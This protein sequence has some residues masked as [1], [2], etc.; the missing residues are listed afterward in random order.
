MSHEPLRHEPLSIK[1]RFVSILGLDNVQ[2]GSGTQD[3]QC[4]T[5]ERK[6][7]AWIW[8]SFFASSK[9][10]PDH[11]RFVLRTTIAF[12][13]CIQLMRPKWQCLYKLRWK[14]CPGGLMDL[15]GSSFWRRPPRLRSW[16][17]ACKTL[18]PSEATWRRK[19][20]QSSEQHISLKATSKFNV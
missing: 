20:R 19:I 11:F 17:I 13:I 5:R 6:T 4:A 10:T 16:D 14:T 8:A 18:P 15:G 1:A 3:R 2:E 7:S 12:C 9:R